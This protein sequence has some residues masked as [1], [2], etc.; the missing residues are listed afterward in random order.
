[1][2]LTAE[3]KPTTTPG[4]EATWPVLRAL[5]A[6][7]AQQV[8][9]ACLGALAR[10]GSLQRLPGGDL[11]A[12]VPAAALVPLALTD[13][14]APLTGLGRAEGLARR[15]AAATGARYVESERA[16]FAIALDDD[17]DR[18][19]E[20]SVGSHWSPELG[21]LLSQR[22]EALRQAQG[23]EENLAQGVE[24]TGAAR[25]TLSGPGI[26]DAAVI[27]VAGLS[28]D[29]FA[30]RAELTRAFPTGIDLLLI[31]DVGTMIGIPRT[32]RI[33]VC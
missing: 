31:T 17:H 24:R 2:T 28:G 4:I 6:G 20:L 18:L 21:V 7:A 32:T 29:F 10:P 1:M 26:K 27:T 23:A 13:L 25:L 9:R 33:E 30:A 8:F 15:I 14:M 11:P 12:T 16:R 3:P 5:S 19:A 22:V